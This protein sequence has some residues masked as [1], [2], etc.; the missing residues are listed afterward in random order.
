[1]PSA[2]TSSR[3]GTRPTTLAHRDHDAVD[4]F[5]DHDVAEFLS[6][7]DHSRVNQALAE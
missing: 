5:P 2:L 6:Q 1:M 4:V 3:V 7:P